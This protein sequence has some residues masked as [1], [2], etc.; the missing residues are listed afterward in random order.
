MPDVAAELIKNGFLGVAVLG[1]SIFVWRMY[2]G[3]R[4]VQ[5]RRVVEAQQVLDKLLELTNKWNEAIGAQQSLLEQYN[6]ALGSMKD[7]CRMQTGQAIDMIKKIDQVL[8]EVRVVV[9][10]GK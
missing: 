4:E 3:M 1:L 7:E 2:S 9:G 5:E 10:K 6:A 8:G